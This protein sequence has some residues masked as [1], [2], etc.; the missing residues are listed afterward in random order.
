MAK[1][2]GN[3][4]KSNFGISS[5]HSF[6]FSGPYVYYQRLMDKYE[7][8]PNKK[9]GK[10]M[11]NRLNAFTEESSNKENIASYFMNMANIEFNKEKK[12]LENYFETKINYSLNDKDFTKK[13]IITLNEALNIKDVFERNLQVLLNNNGQ[14][15]LISWFPTYFDKAFK[16]AWSYGIKTSDWNV[17][18]HIPCIREV[19]KRVLKKQLPEDDEQLLEVITKIL[20]TY[21]DDITRYAV[22]LMFDAGVETHVDKKYQTAYQEVAAA[23][24]NMTK[25]AQQYI[26]DLK[27]IF[28]LG[29]ISDIFY[30]NIKDNNL[31]KI[32]TKVSGHSHKN[33]HQT[34]GYNMESFINFTVN[35]VVSK[36]LSPKNAKRNIVKSYRTGDTGQKADVI[37]TIGINTNAVEKFLLE[38][39]FGTR[40]K[41][42]DALQDLQKR[43]KDLK[44]GFIVY[45]NAKNYTVRSD[46]SSYGFSAGQAIKLRAFSDMLSGLIKDARLFTLGLMNTIPGAI[47]EKNYDAMRTSMARTI[48]TFLFDDFSTI[49]TEMK[50]DTG[51]NAIHLF[52]LQG[53]YVPLSWFFYQLAKAFG[54]KKGLTSGLVRVT[55]NKPSQIKYP[56]PRKTRAALPEQYNNPGEAWRAQRDEALDQIKIQMHFLGAIKQLLS[57]FQ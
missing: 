51:T 33:I 10:V 2:R 25:S 41:D 49:G 9:L 1:K 39:D 53:I 8:E 16:Q 28:H 31:G 37:F 47:N 48:A 12:M 27:E 54:N 43:V 6:K 13:L 23:M 20:D 56:E 52:S 19:L 24:K 15:N 26:C 11:S 34:G 55:I 50:G 17:P 32:T 42:R 14:K 36:G 30:T 40:V 38:N 22:V 45:V 44:D 57:E 7:S 5:N 4:E 29:E 46:F 35:E 18:I 3:Y 21:L